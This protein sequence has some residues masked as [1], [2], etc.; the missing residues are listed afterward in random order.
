LRTDHG[1]NVSRVELSVGAIELFRFD[2]YLHAFPRH[3]HD[4]FTI[5]VFDGDNGVISLGR[6]SARATDGSILAIAP[7][8][9][10]SAEPRRDRGWTYR[11][12]YP[13]REL[14]SVALESEITD[15]HFVTPVIADRRMAAELLAIQVALSEGIA[16]L[17]IEERLLVA[18]RSLVDRHA[19]RS[20][21]QDPRSSSIAV[22]KARWYLESNFAQ[23]IKLVELSAECG[24]S[25]FHLIRSFRHAVG[26]TPHAYLMQTRANR[27]REM[28]VRG[29]GISTVAYRC[30]FVDQSHLTR[31]FKRI[32][33]VTPGAYFA[34]ARRS[35]S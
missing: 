33:G 19:V 6:T 15:A 4:C 10:H 31:T 34:G 9:I 23:S 13:S 17:G 24:V 5:G 25:P 30:G 32:F 35:L 22:S 28:L 1:V 26:M 21:H 8:T 11:S 29:D 18:L 20:R 14:M 27:A 2:H 7:E 3:A 16:T 12:L